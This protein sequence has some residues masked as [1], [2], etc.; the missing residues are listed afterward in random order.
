MALSLLR[1]KSTEYD[2]VLSD[3]YMPG[4]YLAR[5]RVP[6]R[7]QLISYRILLPRYGRLQASGGRGLGNGPSCYQ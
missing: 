1:D 2:L 7:L 5:A 4:V 3:V 6:F